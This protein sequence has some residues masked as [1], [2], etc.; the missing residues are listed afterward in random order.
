MKALGKVS[1]LTLA[2]QRT[3]QPDGGVA[4]FKFKPL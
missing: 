1:T 2:I 3:G 4:E